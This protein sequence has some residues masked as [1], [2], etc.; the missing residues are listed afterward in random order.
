MNCIK[1]YMGAAGFSIYFVLSGLVTL[2]L[3]QKSAIP[4]D[5]LS[6]L[7]LLANFAMVGSLTLFF[8]PAP[9]TMK[10]GYLI[11]TGDVCIG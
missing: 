11:W 9:L 7:S 1:A 6:F 8:L 2:E 3:L 10:Q 4:L 5:V